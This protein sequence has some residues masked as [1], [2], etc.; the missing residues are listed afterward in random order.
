MALIPRDERAVHDQIIQH[1]LVGRDTTQLMA[2]VLI[3]L[4]RLREDL[5]GYHR[6]AAQED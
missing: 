3:E 2:M 5:A 6:P 1:D 4:R